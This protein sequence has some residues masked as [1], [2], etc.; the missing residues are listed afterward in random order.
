MRALVAGP[1]YSES[2]YGYHSRE[3]VRG[4]IYSQTKPLFGLH[5][6]WGGNSEAPNLRYPEISRWYLSNQKLFSSILDPK[7]GAFCTQNG[8]AYVAI[9]IPSEFL[10][11]SPNLNVGV[12][13]GLETT[14]C[15]NMWADRCNNM[16]LLIVPT[17]FASIMLR[18]SGVT[19]PIVVV[20]EIVD[21]DIFNPQGDPSDVFVDLNA[22]KVFV[23]GGQWGAHLE[24]DRKNVVN[25]IRMFMRA[26]EGRRDVALVLKIHINNLSPLDFYDVL[27]A[28]RDHGILPKPEYP[29]IRLIHGYLEPQA[30]SRLYR[31][32]A[33]VGYLSLSHGEGFGRFTAEALACGTP[34]LQT[35]WS[36]PVDFV[37]SNFHVPYKLVPV[38]EGSY[39]SDYIHPA[40]AWAEPIE[41]EVID[42]MRSLAED[43]Q[44]AREVARV[45]AQTVCQDLSISSV[46]KRYNAVFSKTVLSI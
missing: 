21:T 11:H 32:P 29:K 24:D 5:L 8:L 20:P 13:A 12:T 22:E 6:L 35:G 1:F 41:S 39:N 43:P 26:F 28:L 25:T 10:R 31:N 38:P 40:A 2:G 42:R 7:I 9:T 37:P 30:M 18:S 27:E 44:P 14:M 16:D 46:M 23:M 33:V 4:L 45:A 34:I 3:V 36:G 15:S 19:T 17:S